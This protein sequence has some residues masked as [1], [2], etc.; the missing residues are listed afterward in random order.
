MHR[1]TLFSPDTYSCFDLSCNAGRIWLN[2]GV[3]A[4]DSYSEPQA[5]GGVFATTHWSVVLAAGEQQSPQAAE[6][7]EKLCRTYWYPLYVYV[8]RRGYSPQDAQD[9]TQQFF[10]LFLEKEY[11]RRANPERGKFRTFLLHALQNFLANEWKRAQCLK[12]GGG[13]AFLS[14]DVA[15]AEQRY[16][17]EPATAA[18]PERAYEKRWAMTLLEQVLA[19]L[20]QEYARAGNG[21]RVRGAGGLTLGQGRFD[22]LCPNRSKPG[23]G[24]RRRPRGDAPV[25]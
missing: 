19:G 18:T 22:F 10:A 17:I 7:L 13:A 25:A 20:Q 12:R 21:P 8:R 23:H 16:A 6:A 3:R 11:F 24:R 4:E 15:A 1:A 14:L 5:H 9:L 2:R